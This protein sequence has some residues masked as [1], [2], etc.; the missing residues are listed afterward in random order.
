MFVNNKRITGW[1][2]KFEIFGST[3][4]HDNLSGT[5]YSR[6]HKSFPRRVAK[7]VGRLGTSL[8]SSQLLGEV[9]SAVLSFARLLTR[10]QS[11]VE[12]DPCS[13]SDDV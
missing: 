10:V 1:Q 12:P 5:A 13:H 3:I 8:R 4:C 9:D 2:N 11:R 6:L 7:F